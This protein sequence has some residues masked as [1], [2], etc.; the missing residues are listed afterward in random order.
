M[1]FEELINEV[2]NIVQ[3]TAWSEATIK[4]KLNNALIVVAT[5]V[6]LPGKYQLSPPLP[7]LYTSTDIDTVAG[8]ATCNLPSDFNRDVIQVVNSNGDKIPIEVSFRKFL[9]DYPGQESG[10]VFKVAVV[11]NKLVYRDVPATAETLTVHYYKNPSTLINYEDIPSCLPTL[12]HRPLLVGYACKEIFGQ[13]E[14][15]IEGQKINTGY[16]TQEFQQGLLDL[17]VLIP[18]DG[19]PMYVTDLEDRL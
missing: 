8:V 16:W 19:D 1:T 6:M 17:D 5:G 7:D 10:S 13:I 2:T 15:G 12:L 18:N 4:S 3:D 9:S 14:D 11:G